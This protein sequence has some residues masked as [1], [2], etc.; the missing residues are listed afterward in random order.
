[1]PVVEVCDVLGEVDV[2]KIGADD[3]VDIA[4]A[5]PPDAVEIASVVALVLTSVV[6]VL[7]DLVVVVVVSLPAIEA[8][9]DIGP[10]VKTTGVRA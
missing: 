5:V 7:V 9:V 10:S 6:P 4:V 8:D 2:D 1:M 3:C